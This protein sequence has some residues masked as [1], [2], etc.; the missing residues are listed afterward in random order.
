MHQR[1]ATTEREQ[2]VVVQ[3]IF[4]SRGVLALTHNGGRTAR[5]RM[6]M[7]NTD[8]QICKDSVAFP[9][10][11]SRPVKNRGKKNPNTRGFRNEKTVHPVLLAIEPS[12]KLHT[13]AGT[14]LTRRMNAVHRSNTLCVIRAMVPSSAATFDP[15]ARP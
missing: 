9:Q 2:M 10:S 14:R 11:I 12:E 1:I 7:K 3:A 6:A 5:G 4:E 13:K 15:G 8:A